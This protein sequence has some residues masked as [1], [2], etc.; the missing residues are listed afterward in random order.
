MIAQ[1]IS[2]IVIAFAQGWQLALVILATLPILVV[3]GASMGLFYQRFQQA[4]LDSYADAGAVAEQVFGGIRTVASFSLQARFSRLYDKELD[5]ACAKGQRRG[6]MLGVQFAIFMSVFFFTYGLAFWFGNKMI[7]EGHMNG[8]DVLIAFFSMM[9]GAFSFVSL[10]PN[11]TAIASACAAAYRIFPVIDRVPD[12]DPDMTTGIQGQTL[13][14]EIDF[15]HVDFA[16]PTRADVPVLHDFNLHIKAGQTVALVGSSGSG[17]S[18]CVQLLQRFYDPIQGGV[19]LDGHDIRDYNLTWYRRQI[20]VVSQEP[21]LFNMSIKKN[22][23]MGATRKVTDEEMVQACQRAN[24]HEFISGLPQGYDTLL[25]GQ[26]GTLSGG[27]KQR[28]SIARAIIRSPSI[29][30]LDEVRRRQSRHVLM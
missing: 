5:V 22:L 21:V 3:V 15:R 19:Y 26:G 7:Y 20:G 18:T 24:I 27:Q 30:L 17:K 6:L 11:I 14:G 16:Y 4:A 23:L 25:G 2:G 9:V 8:T 10:P 1:A 13:R 29:L 28:I 12:I